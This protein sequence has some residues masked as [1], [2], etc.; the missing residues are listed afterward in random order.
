[1][2]RSRTRGRRYDNEPK[3]NLKKVVG[4]IIAL[5]VIIMIIVS[6]VNIVKK[7]DQTIEV[8]V[9]SYYT[10]YEN[11]GFGVINND[12]EIVNEPTY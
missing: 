2:S 1:M 12:G 7:S 11:G 3:L 5:A 6:I 10:V 8:K 9:Y 4:V